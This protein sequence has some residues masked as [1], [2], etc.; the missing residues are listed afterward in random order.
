[1]TSKLA[2]ISAAMLVAV[3]T[4]ASPVLAQPPQAQKPDPLSEDNLLVWMHSISSHTLLE[5]VKEMAAEKYR[6]RLTGT[7]EYDAIADRYARLF[8]AWTIKPAGDQGTYLQ[9]FPNPYTLVLP[10]AELALAVPV[11][12]GVTI[13]KPYVF[14]QDFFP[15]STSDSGTVTAEVVYVGYGATAPELNYDDYAGVDVRGKIVMME[16]EVPV[17]A[18]RDAE[19]FKKWRP[20]SFHDYKVRNAAQHGAAGMIY[21]YHI[22]NP[23][24]VFVK[25]LL[26]TYVGPSVYNDIFAG[27]G[28]QHDEVV[29]TIRAT[30]KP[31]SFSTGKVVTM[32]NVTEHH[33]EGIGSNVV[34][35]LEGTDPALKSEAIVIGAHLDHLGL[36]DQLMPGANDNA[37]GA[38]VLLGVAEAIARSGIPLKRTVVFVLFG[39]EEQGVKGSEYYVAHPFVPNE[40]VKACF[41]LESVGRG[42]RI[43]AGGGKNYPQLWDVLD[44][45][46][47]KYIHRQASAG[48][49]AN[50]ARPRQDAAHFMWAGVPTISF[51]TGGA[52]PVPFATYHTTKDTAE[53]ITPEIME[54]LARLVYLATIEMATKSGVI[55]KPPISSRS[56]SAFATL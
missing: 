35:Y 38:A 47:R 20:Y 42:E 50:L 22:A 26:L 19:L 49:T 39:A 5:Y 29:K 46:N 48:F 37:S 17:T 15:G 40:R 21:N 9:R 23:N 14:E 44:R 12:G 28:K 27:T 34:G 18:D 4:I 16:P 8:A 54:D 31:A 43:S 25:G 24:S 51:G 11:Q 56:L 6:G 13:R 33:P 36:N 41:N 10:G 1:M 30:L 2:R 52:K 55:E 53:I 3:V 32:K 45:N 7:P